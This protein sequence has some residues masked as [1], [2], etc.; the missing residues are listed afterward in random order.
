MGGA[1][2]CPPSTLV[3]TYGF[4]VFDDDFWNYPT[5]YI[6]NSN[7][8]ACGAIEHPTFYVTEM[9]AQTYILVV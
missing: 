1:E 2:I 9:M 7:K 6:E 3:P 5:F 4:S 8:F